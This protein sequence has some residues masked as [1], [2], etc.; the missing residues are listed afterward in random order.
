MRDVE[1]VRQEATLL[2]EQMHTVKED[3]KKVRSPHDVILLHNDDVIKDDVM[4]LGGEG[5]GTVDA[6]A[7]GAGLDEDSDDGESECAA[8]KEVISI[9]S[10]AV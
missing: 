6:E 8:G 9:L 7:G 2:K 10:T 1:A 3:I 4:F 5:D